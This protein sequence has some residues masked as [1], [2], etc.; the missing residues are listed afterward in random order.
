MTV[1]NSESSELTIVDIFSRDADSKFKHDFVKVCKEVFGENSMNE[2]LFDRKYINNIY[3][4]SVLVVVYSGTRPVAGR[5][6]WRNDVAGQIAYQPCDTAVIGD[7]RKRG[8][9][10]HITELALQ[11]VD[12]KALIYNFPNQ[13]S[14][15]Q[16]VKLGW[17][18]LKMYYSTVLTSIRKYDDQHPELMDDSYFDWW[19]KPRKQDFFFY[20]KAESV[21]IVKEKKRWNMYFIIARIN[22]NQ[23][24]H[25]QKIRTNFPI[26]TY[27]GCE[28]KFYNKN[29]KPF[30]IVIRSRS[31]NINTI[32]IPV[33]KSD[34]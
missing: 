34:M 6:L 29:R 17:R 14:Y 32:S 27:Y 5:A 19:Y 23:A 26:L 31:E 11:R 2:V 7:F 21:Y 1:I 10:R 9:F 16:Y 4:D 33:W 30:R 3:G 13:N 22:S 28:R 8:I 25:L 24:K 12:E 15:S 20:R 18:N